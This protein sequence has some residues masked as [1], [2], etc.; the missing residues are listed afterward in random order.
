MRPSRRTTAPLVSFLDRRLTSFNMSSQG[1]VKTQNLNECKY[2]LS[3]CY[4]FVVTFGKSLLTVVESNV[5]RFS[6]RDFESMRRTFFA[7]VLAILQVG[8]LEA[9]AL[10]EEPNFIAVLEI[11]TDIGPGITVDEIQ[12]FSSVLRGAVVD[13]ASGTKL[14]VMTRETIDV[15][16]KGEA[17]KCLVGKCLVDIGRKL[18]ANFVVGGEIKQ[19]GA[20]IGVMI[21]AY[22]TSNG[23]ALANEQG[24]ATSVN[25]LEAVIRAVGSRVV[26]KVTG[27]PM[28]NTAMSGSIVG[29]GIVMDGVTLDRGESIVNNITDQTG[30]LVVQTEPVGATVFLNGVEL[31]AASSPIQVEKMVGRYVIVAEMGKMYH[32]ARQEIDLPTSGKTVTLKLPVA[33]GRLTVDS[34]PVGAD[35]WLEGEQVGTTPWSI[36]RKPSGTYEIRLVKQHYLTHKGMVVVKDGGATTHRVELEQNF[37]TLVITSDPAGAEVV[38]NDQPTGQ[39]TPVTFEPVQPGIVS[40]KLIKS[41]YGDAVGQVKVEN[42]KTARLDQALTA[43]TGLLVVTSSYEDGSVCLGDVF[44]DGTRAGKTPFKQE[45]MAVDHE[46]HVVCEKGEAMTIAT[47]THNE[48]KDVSMVIN[49]VP[50]VGI[51]W[52]RIPGGSFMMGSNSG[53]TDARPVHRVVVPPFDMSRNEVTFGQFK[54]CVDAGVCTAPHVSD[55]QCWR[56]IDGSWQHAVL[57]VAAQGDNQP[58]TCVD[59]N[60]AVAFAKWAGGR[61]PSESEWEYAA[62]SG[63]LDQKYPWGNNEP[64]CRLAIMSDGGWGCGSNAPWSVCSKPAGNTRQGLCD[65]AGNVW[66]WVQD[67]WHEDYSG[68]P[69][70]GS[71]REN[72]ADTSYRAAR[73]GCYDSD[74]KWVGTTIRR[75]KGWISHGDGHLGFRVVRDTDF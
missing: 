25:D 26:A 69:T 35:V 47:V 58:V 16:F 45:V 55:N 32:P 34:E 44:I 30:F 9:P 13:G 67:C 5:G 74:V 59:W 12:Y 37:G 40:V 72:C 43:K 60:Q 17:V 8:L 38:I 49:T 75:N 39:V 41:G 64:S 68:A 65:M 48:R 28:P 27:R 73:G 56:F 18:Q 52:V 63:G 53:E 24:T 36:E 15:F 22:K 71:A 57:P 66:E 61:L 14:E 46:V 4:R 20:R 3:S 62:R 21:E 2:S 23:T 50:D 51:A 70:D 29:S 33:Y 31:G 19:V 10:A 11:K 54:K 7:F 42:R 1:V 6:K